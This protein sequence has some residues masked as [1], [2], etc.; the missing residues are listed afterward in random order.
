MVETHLAKQEQIQILEYKIF[1][2]SITANRKSIFIFIKEKLT[3]I[4]AEVIETVHLD[5]HCGYCLVIRKH[6]SK[7]ESYIVPKKT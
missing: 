7:W 2:N 5:K 3:T 1:R 4:A 6:K